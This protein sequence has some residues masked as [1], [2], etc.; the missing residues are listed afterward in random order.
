MY[1][2]GYE[3]MLIVLRKVKNVEMYNKRVNDLT[4]EKGPRTSIEASIVGIQAPRCLPQ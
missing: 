1:K 3:N 4:I 2:N